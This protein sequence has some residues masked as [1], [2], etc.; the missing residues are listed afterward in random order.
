[1]ASLAPAGI[2]ASSSIIILATRSALSGRLLTVWVV[3]LNEAGDVG[4][5]CS[6]TAHE[7]LV[8]ILA[9]RISSVVIHDS[10]GRNPCSG[11]NDI[12]RGQA[13]CFG[14][15]DEIVG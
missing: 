6:S 5:I 10:L 12:V 3:L 8:D 14:A 4:V 7:D 9:R 13:L 15:A 11:C 1:M 2:P